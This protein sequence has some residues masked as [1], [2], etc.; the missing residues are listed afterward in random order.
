MSLT[1][2][3]DSVAS[4]SF[5]QN[6][7]PNRGYG[8]VFGSECEPFTVGQ[9]VMEVFLGFAWMA[10]LYCGLEVVGEDP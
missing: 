1:F 6:P 8:V 4:A 9:L 5:N 2:A 7:L 10:L 3:I